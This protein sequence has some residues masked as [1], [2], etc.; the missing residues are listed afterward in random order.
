MSL[1]LL[2][3]F[4]AY[5]AGILF[6]GPQTENYFAFATGAVAI[7][8]AVWIQIPRSRARFF[9]L[10]V[11]TLLFALGWFNA[12]SGNTPFPTDH[13]W[14]HLQ[15][16]K[17]ARVEAVIIDRPERFPDKTRYRIS[18]E[19]INY[20]AGWIAVSG[21]GQINL[22]GEASGLRW[23]DRVQFPPIRLKRPLNFR[24][25]GR[26]DFEKFM[27]SRGIDVTGGTARWKNLK[28]LGQ[29][30][31]PKWEAT[32][33]SL[34]D[35]MSAILRQGLPPE[36]G[37][38]VSG[39]VFGEK[40]GMRPEVMEAYRVTGMGHLLAV[41]GL[42]IGFVAL[43][44]F[45]VGQR[46]LFIV[47][48]R[49]KNEWAQYGYARKGAAL[50][51][52]LA[53]L[54][55]MA[56]VGPKVSSIRAGILVMA[57]LIALW[58][59]RERQILNTLLLAGLLILLWDPSAVYQVGFQLSFSAVLVIVLALKW[60][61]EPTDDPLEKMGEIPWYRRWAVRDV[62]T[63][64][65]SRR[66]VDVLVA[67]A[68]ISMAAYIG[69]FPVM[70]FQF[71]QVSLVS[72][73]MNI[74]LVP[75]ASIVIP[76]CLLVLFLGILLPT[77][78]VFLIQPL[79]WL[80]QLFIHIPI[81]V[82]TLPDM[83]VYLPSPSW[84]WLWGYA[85]FFIGWAYWFFL[86]RRATERKP[87]PVLWARYVPWGLIGV[88]CVLVIELVHPR[89]FQLKNDRLH[90][91][92]LDVGQGE[93]L[94]IEFP[95]G[96]NLLLDGGGFFKGALDVGTRVV[97]SFLW[98]R[99][100]GQV[101]YL[102]ATHSDQ[103]HIDG[104]ESVLENMEVGHFL[105][106]RD[107]MSDRRYSQLV[108]RAVGRGVPLLEFGP[109]H[110]L[111]MGEVTL[112]HLHPTEAYNLK[113]GGNKKGRLN[114]NQSWVVMLEYREFRMLLTGDIS[115]KAER[116]LVEQG[117]DLK[118]QVLKSPHHGSK[119]SSSPEFLEAVAPRDILISSGFANYF[120]HP[121]KRVMRRYGQTGARVWNTAENGALHLITDGR[122]YQIE[123]H[124]YLSNWK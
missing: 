63:V 54:F 115:E 96:Q 24:N 70:L 99:G 107:G 6:V 110:P 41:S 1:P 94:F 2:P 66:L 89:V 3:W 15:Y 46:V 55:Y 19:K 105:S 42:H 9:R 65:W 34:R 71:H 27:Q 77:V 97:G 59:N 120:H 118:A 26:F 122:T 47:M 17:R 38:M 45:W 51:A 29:E 4:L 58:I 20:G 50:W 18:L 80:A 104:V 114:N 103:D 60:V 25:P 121:H 85:I 44:F 100:I 61:A 116:W 57:V 62:P 79:G 86:Y 101:D 8:I 88:G 108:T 81:G 69:T 21:V 37:A 123:T 75:L 117:A 98:S 92:L 56:L 53:V 31:L 32:L 35:D 11:L 76:A 82:A 67:S 113:A 64:G 23:G 13:I 87:L 74:L 112:T 68:F 72:P 28:V 5:F 30:P 73:L 36:V 78:A 93:S 33:L 90:V 84:P 12:H 7:A 40:S 91:W 106:R 102:G 95:D 49:F 16:D 22:Y 39:L 43:I 109:Q 124:E 48:W 52:L 111:E 10:I 119:T 14:S 83:S